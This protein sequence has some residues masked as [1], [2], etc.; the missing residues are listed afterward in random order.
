MLGYPV[1]AVKHPEGSQAIVEEWLAPGLGC[2]SL[3][4]E[5]TALLPNV[6]RY[7][8]TT[9]QVLQVVTGEPDASLFAVPNWKEMDPNA[10]VE[11]YRLRYGREQRSPKALEKLQAVYERNH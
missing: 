1:V 11:E 10:E 5:E 4:M 9:Q 7:I 6:G 8:P 3:L 2:Y